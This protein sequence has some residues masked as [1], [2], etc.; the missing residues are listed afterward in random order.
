MLQKR[1]DTAGNQPL[2]S[3]QG[4]RATPES[5][6]I[7]DPGDGISF[8]VIGDHGGV[9]DPNPQ[10]AVAAAMAAELT[11]PNPPSFILSVGDAV[12]FDGDPAQYMPQFW[13]PYAQVPLPIVGVPGNH[14]GD[15]TDGVPG[16]GIASWMANWCDP[17]GP[18]SPLGDPHDEFGRD[19]QTQPYCYW[20][21]NLKSATLI[22]LYSNVASGGYLDATQIA[23]L[24][25]ELKAAAA[26]LPLIVYLHHPPYSIDAFHGGSATMGAT[27]DG[28][29]EAAGRWPTAV[30]AGHIHDLQS[31]VRSVAGQQVRYIV[32]GAGGYHNLHS[33]AGDYTPGMQLQGG[34]TVEYAYAD[35]WGFL[36]LTASGGKLAGEFVQVALDGT[37]TH[38]ANTF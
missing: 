8:L 3:G 1:W 29:F 31:M 4:G 32:S 33:I 7:K 11:G 12:Y 24:T 6:G 9:E 23:W 15:P 20:T 16:A 27:L 10:K 26:D 37:V 34:V 22:G 21:L 36:K 28:C 35:S 25:G 2:P 19:T 38:N 17:E 18:R 5:V 13:Q 30:I 14:D